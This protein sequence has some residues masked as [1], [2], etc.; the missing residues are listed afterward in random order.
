MR[1]RANTPPKDE[2]AFIN[3]GTA[4]LN[5]VPEKVSTVKSKAKPVSIS[6]ADTN[7]KSIDNCIRDEMN[8]TGHRVN[9]SDVVRAAVMAFESLNQHERSELI[10][11]AKLQ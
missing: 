1:N 7:L 5:A 3:G 2:N 8:N 10:Q 6:F 11:K 9:R 4:G